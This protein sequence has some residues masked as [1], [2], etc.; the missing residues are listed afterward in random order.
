M[1]STNRRVKSKGFVLDATLSSPYGNEWDI[2]WLGHCGTRCGRGTPYYRR[3]DDLTAIPASSLPQYWAGP[4]IH[5]TIDKAP[6]TRLV[7]RTRYA[8]YTNAYAVTYESAKRILA[9]L[10]VLPPDEIIPPGVD[11]IFDVSFGRFCEMGI[12]KCFSSFP[13][14][15]GTW[16]PPALDM[17]SRHS[18]IQTQQHIL[19]EV[20]EP[21]PEPISRG[22]VYSTMIN[23]ATLLEGGKP[24]KSAVDDVSQPELDLN[25]TRPDLGGKMFVF[26]DAT[27][28]E[29]EV[30]FWARLVGL[31]V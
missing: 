7:C 4:A 25:Y 10:M 21:F 13:S 24:V 28:V 3:S 9:A 30:S 22:V 16:K 17:R 2:L 23:I 12:F 6:N 19:G 27:A 11:S 8:I 5:E 20:S 26:D 29:K 31:F 1:K 15:M 18:D 14:L